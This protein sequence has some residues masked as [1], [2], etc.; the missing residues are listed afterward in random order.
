MKMFLILVSFFMILGRISCSS[1]EENKDT[2]EFNGIPTNNCSEKY[3]ATWFN[4]HFNESSP[5]Y[6][7]AGNTLNA[8]CYLLND[9]GTMNTAVSTIKKHCG[10]KPAA[11]MVQHVNRA[12]K[13]F[14][15]E[16]APQTTISFH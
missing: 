7:K 11:V 6:M 15:C 10:N 4:R 3:N 5:T 1:E 14:Q 16:L 13:C 8:K 2:N 9:Q 12:R